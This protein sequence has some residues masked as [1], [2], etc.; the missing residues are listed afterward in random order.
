MV[1]ELLAPAGSYD[2]FKIAINLGADAVYLAG[3]NFGARAYAEN[4][5]TEEIKKKRRICSFKQC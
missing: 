5:N 2:V 3:Q 4:F 1:M